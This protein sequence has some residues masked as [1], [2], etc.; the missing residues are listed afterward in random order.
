MAKSARNSLAIF[1]AFCLFLSIGLSRT[2]LMAFQ[3]E[4]K[5]SALGIYVGYSQPIYD[6]WIRISQY[7]TVRDGTKLAVDI[8]RPAKKGIPENNPLPLIWMHTRYHRANYTEDGKIVSVLDEPWLQQILKHGYII[9]AADVRGGGASYGTRR[10]PFTPEEAQDAYDLTEWFARQPWCDGNIGMVGGSY[11]GITQYIAA[12]M[13]PPHLKAIMP[14]FAMFDMYSFSHPGGVYQDDFIREWSELVKQLD[15][16]IPTPPVDEDPDSIMAKEA[17][18][19]HQ[20]NVYPYQFM[21]SKAYR[22]T[23]IPGTLIQPSLEWSPHSYLA[24]I[25]ETTPQVAVYTVA[26]WFDLWP[27]DALTWFANLKAPQKIVITPWP[28]STNS[29]GWKET[30]R[31]LIGFD[32]SF[33]FLA[34][35]LRWFDYW[36]KGIDNGIMNEPPVSYF[37]M[38][39]PQEN[40]WKTAEDWP[41]PETKR[42]SFYFHEGPSGSI[43]SINDGLLKKSRPSG[44]SAADTYQVDYS[45]TTGTTTRW[46][47]GRGEGFGYGNMAENDAKALTYTTEPL[48]TEMEVTGHPVVT[49]WASSTADDGDFFAYLE[50]VDQE[51]YSHYLTEGVLRASHRKLSDPPFEY[52]GIPYH[53]SFAEDIEPM[54]KGEP[55]QLVFD[56]QPTSNIFDAGHR[57]RITITCADQSTFET[58][59]L[60]PPPTVRVYRNSARPSSIILPVVLPEGEVDVAME[61][62]SFITVVLVV[63][64]VVLAVIFLFFFLR[65]RMKK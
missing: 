56:L 20:S 19:M 62:L 14:V 49:L 53:R 3:E 60:T 42:T 28:H 7:V 43:G 17:L 48:E 18:A 46:A 39:A 44:R 58:P 59:E 31:P 57:V 29:K 36:L 4:A 35:H 34:E 38:G 45:T 27:R 47:D 15:T 6:G 61:P 13:A 41:L 63:L 5:V 33:D 50:E 40:A 2:S 25:N 8:H 1:L 10:G 26:G 24:R 55:V 9:A 64:V 21:S 51:G 54:P 65:S 30:A 23:T 16:E 22:D 32:F 37:T 52:L 11:L 12:G